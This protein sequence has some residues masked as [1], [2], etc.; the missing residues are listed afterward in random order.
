[1]ASTLVADA[2]GAGVEV[3][4]VGVEPLHDECR[5]LRLGDVA[6]ASRWVLFP[7]TSDPLVV[8]GRLPVPRQERRRLGGLVAAGI[9]FPLTY[10]AHEIPPPVGVDAPGSGPGYLQLTLQHGASLL[11][12][13]GPSGRSREIARRVGSASRGVGLS[14]GVAT[15]AAASGL[16]AV[17]SVNAASAFAATAAAGLGIAASVLLV[18][19][20]AGLDP[21]VFGARPLPGYPVAPGTP[22]AWFVLA[23]WCW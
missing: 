15:G 18:A 22:A 16:V 10:L 7:A 8:G 23:R 13:V 1:M 3:H 5:L 21:I 14:L 4:Y 17:G 6:D 12:S 11:P 9:E 19:G 2:R 20:V